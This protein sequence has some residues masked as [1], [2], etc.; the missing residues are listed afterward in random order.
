MTPPAAED[1]QPGREQPGKQPPGGPTPKQDELRLARAYLLRVA[2][3]PALALRVFVA[4]HGPVRAAELVRAGEVPPA[5]RQETA[6]RREI[7]QAEQDLRHAAE[8]GARLVCPEDEE[9]PSWRFL[10]LELAA[11]RGIRY[12]GEP[13]ALW[14]RGRS[15]D[16]LGEASV[17]IVGSRA[18]TGYGEHVAADFASRIAATGAGIVSGAAYGIDAA[19]HRGA[20]A[21]GAT[22]VAVLACGVDLVYPSGNDRL[23]TRIFE[24]GSLVS[25]Y[26]PGSPPARFRF[27]V[28]NRLIAAFGDATVI[29]EAGRRSGGRNTAATA[30]AL[31]RPVLAVPGPVTSAMSV[32]CH[33]LLRAG[34]ALI[35]AEPADVTTLIGPLDAAADLP[36]DQADDPLD[37][38]GENAKRILE[39]L[40]RSGGRSAERVAAES[41]VSLNLVRALL[42]DLELS[43][44]TTATE[45][46]WRRTVRLSRTP[47]ANAPRPGA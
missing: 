8:A 6:S 12:S 23:F 13:L 11:R 3:P 19:A 43:G 21:G 15:L 40:P 33:E 29:V 5:V 27:L 39:A 1:Q 26:P 31:G 16:Q 28:R 4:E 46:G 41:G 24:H 2:E 9:W 44:F 25:E 36:A 7:D 18:A 32:G 20:I 22:T 10:S 30:R 47:H 34:D 38:L 14:V 35:A 45:A 37:E 42:C 17:A